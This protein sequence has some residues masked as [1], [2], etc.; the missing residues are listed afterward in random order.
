M[1]SKAISAAVAAVMVTIASPAGAIEN[2]C[3]VTIGV[4]G[5]LVKGW[6]DITVD[7]PTFNDWDYFTSLYKEAQIWDY[8]AYHDPD[9]S[10]HWTQAGKQKCRMFRAETEA[11]FR[12]PTQTWETCGNNAYL[13][14]DTVPPSC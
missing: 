5:Q 13:K 7:A 14:V 9:S 4:Y 8:E 3:L 1:R 11:A 10:P 6:H 2:T 12:S